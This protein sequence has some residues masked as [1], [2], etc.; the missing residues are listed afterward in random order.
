MLRVMKKEK[1]NELRGK[2]QE[3]SGRTR[4]NLEIMFQ[5]TFY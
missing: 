2:S 1:R 4:R 3:R 5:G